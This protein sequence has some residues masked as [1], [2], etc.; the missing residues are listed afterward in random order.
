MKILGGANIP[1]YTLE[2]LTP[3]AKHRQGSYE[4]IVVPYVELGRDKRCG[5]EFGDDTPTVSRRHCAIERKGNETSIINLSSSNPTLVNGRPVQERYFLNNGDEI[6]LSVEGPRLRF[7]TTKTGTAKMGF[8]NKMN[9]VMMQAIKPYKTAAIAALA[10]IIL[11]AGGGAFAIVKLNEETVHLASDLE[12]QKELTKAQADSLAAVKKQNEALAAELV[13]NKADLE[14]TLASERARIIK[15]NEKLTRSLSELKAKNDSLLSSN[16]SYV[17]L[18]EPLKKYTLA[19]FYNKIVVEYGGS[20]IAEETYEPDCMCTGFLLEDGTFVTARHCIDAILTDID[21]ANFYDASG[22]SSTL[23]Y[24]AQSYDGSVKIDFTNKQ[25]KA[26]YS[27]DT[28]TDVTFQ[29]MSGKLRSPNY[30]EG[31]D[32]AYLKT[33]Y[34]EGV[35]FDK[36]LSRN[37]KSG[38]ELLVLGYSYGMQYRASGTLEPY[39]ST[40]KVT[41]TGL[42]NNTINVTEAGWD[43]GN[44]GGPIFTEVNGKA[45]CVGLVTGTF[46]KSEYSSSGEAVGVNASIKIVTP[47]CNF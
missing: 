34:T 6:Q 46:R 39:F 4:T 9:L 5:V 27:Q 8:T 41:L 32:W 37:V 45:V 33:S 42:Q 35:P 3:T 18:I 40:A 15:E 44:S 23:Y 22:G 21:A 10:V 14:R 36:D 28:Y 38:T 26:D 24:T 1:T 19:I 31:A 16:K 13:K 43:G 25:M 47:L 11:L 2:Y 12:G 20:I 29:G 30:F 7:N 17:E